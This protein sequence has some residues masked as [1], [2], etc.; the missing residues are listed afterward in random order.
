MKMEIWADIVC[1][2]CYIVK[3]KF[4]MALAAFPAKDKVEIEWR[5]FQLDPTME[6]IPGKSVHR[7]LAERKGCS[8]EEAKDMN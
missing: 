2:F 5:S 6:N 8:L 3:R 7:Y 4:E 1:P